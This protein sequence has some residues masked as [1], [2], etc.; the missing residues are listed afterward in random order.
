MALIGAHTAG[1]QRFVS[2]AVAGSS[3]DTTVDIW[4]V[5]FCGSF[6]V[7]DDFI[8]LKP[9]DETQKGGNATGK[10]LPNF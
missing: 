4:D 2:T 10:Y 5:K 7:V 8:S 9:D 3:F 1:K 6:R